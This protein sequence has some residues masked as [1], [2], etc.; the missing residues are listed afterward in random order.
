MPSFLSISVEISLFPLPKLKAA[1]RLKKPIIAASVQVAFSIVSVDCAT[2]PN[3]LAF[4]KEESK[5]P[6]LEF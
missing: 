5:P 6:P 4:P 2:P 1:R 3:W